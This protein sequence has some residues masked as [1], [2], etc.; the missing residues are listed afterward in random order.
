MHAIKSSP[1]LRPI[2]R[3]ASPAPQPAQPPSRPDSGIAFGELNPAAPLSRPS[4]GGPLKRLSIS[5]IRGKSPARPPLNPV[6][7]TLV[8]DGSYLEALGL[9]LSEAVSRAVA[10]PPQGTQ[11]G[12]SFNGRK[13]IPPGR[14]KALG[15]LIAS[16][17]NAANG[18]PLLQRAITRLLHRPLTVL[19]TNLSNQLLPLF[20]SPEFLTIDGAASNPPQAHALAIAGLAA[21]LLRTFDE[22]SLGHP[23]ITDSRSDGLQGVREGLES[24]T[25]RVLTPL[26]NAIKKDLV[27]I[28]DELKSHPTEPAFL[29]AKLQPGAPKP[30]SPIQAYHPAV[31][32]LQN[33]VT[34]H[35]KN[36]ANYA[37]VMGGTCDT[38]LASLHIN[39]VWHALLA[40][41]HRRAEATGSPLLSAA[42]GTKKKI[43]PPPTPRMAIHFKPIS[44]PPS[45]PVTL[46]VSRAA[47]GRVVCEALRSLPGPK[48]DAKRELA[49][50]VVLEAFQSMEAFCALLEAVDNRHVNI[51][52]EDLDKL[53]EDVPTL[54]ALQVLLDREGAAPQKSVALLLGFEEEQYRQSCLSS[55]GREE[56]CAELVV[57]R[58][59]DVLGRAEDQ[60]S[61]SQ[62]LLAWLQRQ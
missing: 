7:A 53:T 52:P 1:F 32:Q 50:E 17:L 60:T 16:E 8:Q 57:R 43:T 31:V 44:R 61:Y 39:L 10:A 35:S 62:D 36:L 55:F 58:I 26:V 33:R 29:K 25:T 18:N 14:G 45:P 15:A 54:L 24:I 47:D 51:S 38:T 5:T 30:A 42:T 6:P 34:L 19:L 3:P 11:A 56:E 22:L 59:I 40:L 41:A 28:L 27:A 49:C 21:E 48:G 4:S 2:S 37:N 9:K 12:E 23:G 46:P 13:A 20:S